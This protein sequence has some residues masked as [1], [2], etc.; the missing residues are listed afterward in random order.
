MVIVFFL[1]KACIDGSMWAFCF[2]EV[3]KLSYKNGKDVL[4]C[5]L[6]RELQ[7]H[8]QGELIYIPR[9][10]NVRAGWGENN[11]TRQQIRKRNQ[12]IHRLYTKGMGVWELVSRYHLSE[13]SIRKIIGKVS[14][15]QAYL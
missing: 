10:D 14:R 5:E 11:G 13:D 7:K 1:F 2:E 15:E 3:L 4:P 12:E 8:I 9:E 6:L